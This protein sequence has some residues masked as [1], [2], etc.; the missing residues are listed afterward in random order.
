MREEQQVANLAGL[1]RPWLPNLF[2]EF[3]QQQHLSLCLLMFDKHK[4]FAETT[5]VVRAKKRH[6]RVC[7]SLAYAEDESVSQGKQTMVK[8]FKKKRNT[9]A[10]P[11]RNG[12]PPRTR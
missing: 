12:T 3:S 10:S 8:K 9:M 7:D 11:A 1:S 2:Q 4:Y 5:V 6:R